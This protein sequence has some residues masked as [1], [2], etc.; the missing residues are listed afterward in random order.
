MLFSGMIN[1]IGRS[2]FADD[3]SLWRRVRNID[4][5]VE[6]VQQ[7]IAQVQEWGG[8]WGF[9][10]LVEKG[11]FLQGGNWKGCSTKTIW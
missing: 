8:K 6:K 1:D 4:F 9:K 2:L 11:S 10:F 3:G 7:G 5:I